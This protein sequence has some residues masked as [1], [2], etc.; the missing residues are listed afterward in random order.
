MRKMR[1]TTMFQKDVLQSHYGINLFYF[2][3]SKCYS[4]KILFM[5]LGYKYTD[6][7][8]CIFTKHVLAVS[9]FSERQ[10]MVTSIYMNNIYS[11]V[12]ISLRYAEFLKANSHV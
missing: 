11:K 6:T 4:L 9:W 1:L 8:T 3:S 2:T 10:F 12:S 5:Y 7:E